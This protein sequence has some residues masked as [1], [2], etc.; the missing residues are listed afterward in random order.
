MLEI[1]EKHGSYECEFIVLFGKEIKSGCPLCYE[2][3][4]AEEERRMATAQL[5]L[6][7]EDLIK[8]GIEPEYYSKTL[9][10]YKAE[11]PSEKK[12]FEAV[13]KLKTGRCK[14]VLLLGSNGTGKTMLA[15]CLAKDLLGKRVTMYEISARIRQGYNNNKSASELDYLD[16]LLKYPFLAIDEIGR[17]KGSDAELN[18]LSYLIDKAHTRGIRL[19]LISNKHQAQA[20]PKERKSEA[21]EFYLPNDAISRL[22]QN[23]EIVEIQGRDRRATSTAV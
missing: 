19:L 23:S 3:E 21:I 22:R 17:T 20:L 14:K 6:E 2:E 9:K 5:R 4:I 15:S 7:Q 16:S 12:A 8:R 10:D 11:T 1:C 13:M 18:W